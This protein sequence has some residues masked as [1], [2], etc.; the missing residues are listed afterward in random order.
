LARALGARAA[1][2]AAAAALMVAFNWVGQDY[3][4]PQALAMVLASGVVVLLLQSAKSRA[5]AALVLGLFPAIVVSH[6]LTPFWLL[7][8]AAVLVVLRRVPWWLAGVMGLVVAGFLLSRLEVAEAYGLFSGFDPLE[9]AGSSVPPVPALGREVGGLLAR[10][11]SL[12][13]WA[14][15]LVVLGTRA[16]R[17][18]RR[19]GWRSP[20]VLVPAAIAFSPFLLLAGQSYGGEANLRVTL[21]SAIGCCAV[22]GPALVAA[23]RRSPASA[24]AAAAWTALVLVAT[25]QA[26]FQMW[27]LTLIRPEDVAAAQELVEE[28]PEASVVPLINVWPGRTSVDYE[29]Y[30]R[31]FTKLEPGLDEILRDDGAVDPAA[32]IPLDPADVARVAQDLPG[33]ATYVVA[34][35]SMRGYDAYYATYAPGTYQATLQQL[36]RS[37]DW[38]V[39]RH[40]GDLWVLRYLGPAAPAA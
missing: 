9:N 14:A 15:T 23:L 1:G 31:P 11:S 7:A 38:E 12:L 8:L 2:C 39:V 5:A 27:S 18:D 34:T 35:G 22:L 6:Q 30:I 32:S 20:E 3:F 13:V 10:T 24:L 33:E 16:A 37:P 17:L 25:A 26:S 28:H 36:T 21:Y 40:S 29:R 19:R 4:A